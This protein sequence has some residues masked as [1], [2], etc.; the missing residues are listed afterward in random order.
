[1]TSLNTGVLG[2]R[3]GTVFFSSQKGVG[4]LDLRS[5]KPLWTADEPWIMAGALGRDEAYSLVHP[6]KGADLRAYELSSGKART[7]R[8]FTDDISELDG[9]LEGYVGMLTLGFER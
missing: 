1:M 7:V 2:V 6:G 9:G 5:G 8:H 3:D 4:A